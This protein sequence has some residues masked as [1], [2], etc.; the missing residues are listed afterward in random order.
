MFAFSVLEE[1][2]P[3]QCI[4]KEQRWMDVLSPEYNIS[5]TAGSTVG[6]RHTPESIEK[7][8]I[9][10][11]GNQNHRGHHHNLATRIKMR[12]LKLGRPLSLSHRAA[13]SAA[14]LGLKRT[15]ET[16]ANI[17]AALMGHPCSPAT[18]RKISE[19]KRKS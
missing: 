14:G 4:E 13:L 16:C 7:M 5:R 19:A 1:C 6:Y 3:E 9:A 11:L 8:R 18:R 2:P 17:S 12:I 15:P 10:K